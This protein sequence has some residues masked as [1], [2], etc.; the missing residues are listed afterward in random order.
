V[1]YWFL[2]SFLKKEVTWGAEAKLSAAL[3]APTFSI[4][5][6]KISPSSL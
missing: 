2:V 1:S 5:F 4:Y 3:K 6:A